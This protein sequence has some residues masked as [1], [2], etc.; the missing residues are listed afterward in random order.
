MRVNM[1]RA[2]HFSKVLVLFGLGA[3]LALQPQGATWAADGYIQTA[4]YIFFFIG[5]GMGIPQ[6]AAASAYTGKPLTVDTFPAQGVTTTAAFDRFI[7]GS[8]A[9]ATAMASGIKTKIGYVGLDP[10]LRPVKTVAE[11]AK[12]Q[13]KKVGVISSVSIDHATPAA[14]Y[15]HVPSRSMYHEIGMALVKSGFDF[16][17][18]GGFKDPEGKKSK[19]PQ[20]NVLKAARAAGYTL[21]NNKQD[22]MA[23]KR[24]PGLK[25]IAV[26]PWLQDSAALPY[27]IDRRPQ[28]ISLSEFT[29]KAV[30]LLDNPQG[31]FLMVEGGKIDWACHAND[32]VSAIQ[33]TLAFDEAVQVAL[34]FYEKHPRETLI[35][36]TGDH[37]CGGLTLGFAGT[38]YETEFNML[39]HQDTSFKKFSAEV[40]KKFRQKC[41]ADCSFEK[42][43]PVI[44]AHF[45]LK[46]TGD[47]QSDPLVVKP[48]QE[49]LLRQAFERSMAGERIHSDDPGTYLLYGSYDPLTV[50]ITHVLN[51]N[52]GLAW[53]SFKHTGVPVTTSAIGV[54]AELFNGYFDNT[55]LAKKVMSVMGLSPQVV[56]MADA[57]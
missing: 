40:L 38:K 47:P 50:T 43:K 23:L 33:D 24:S 32:A 48:Y 30:E 55:D 56:Y 28:D 31:F 34:R 45:G 37:E 17:G 21:V 16:F 11:M 42:I 36:V 4:K 13:G 1:V 35:V 41:G 54:G 53:T 9:A 44:T 18:G 15:A 52:A 49:A 29:E 12:G 5:D 39:K 46:F 10:Q 20:G 27:H 8:A 26:N 2:S 22:F 57:A 6:R 51:N 14:F 19:A 7:T 25:V 3:L